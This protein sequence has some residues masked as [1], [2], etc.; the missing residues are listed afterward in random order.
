MTDDR[1]GNYT[2]RCVDSAPGIGN[3]QNSLYRRKALSKI[4]DEL[5]RSEGF[6]TATVAAG[7]RI[8]GE[9]C[10]NEDLRIE[11]SVEGPVHLGSGQL[12]IGTGGKLVGDVEAREALI[13]GTLRGNLKAQECIEIKAGGSVVG[14]VLTA[15]I[16]IEDGAH[17]K[18][19]IEIDRKATETL[20]KTESPLQSYAATASPSKRKEA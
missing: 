20:A 7:V 8:R 19:S 6:H 17:F 4:H 9:I 10:G 14:D 2:G 3:S 18:G 13:L 1:A 15:R 5:K 11:G 12:T 16:I